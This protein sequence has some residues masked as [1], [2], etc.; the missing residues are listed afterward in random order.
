MVSKVDEGLL[1]AISM[2]SYLLMQMM[3]TCDV[4]R[5]WSH[6]FSLKVKACP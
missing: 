1:Y 2:S 4:S 5:E 3:K 6:F